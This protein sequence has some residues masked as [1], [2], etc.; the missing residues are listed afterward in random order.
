MKAEIQ[1]VA[2]VH[3]AKVVGCVAI[4]WFGT[5]GMHMLQEKLPDSVSF[6]KAPEVGDAITMVV[7]A[8]FLRNK[9]EYLAAYLGGS[10]FALVMDLKD[11]FGVTI[12]VI[13]G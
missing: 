11:R 4:G 2:S 13:E 8:Y 1:K 9:G 6:L 3:T 5:K 10:G 12:P 7:G